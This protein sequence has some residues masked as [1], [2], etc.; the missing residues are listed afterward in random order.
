MGREYK[1]CLS[2]KDHHGFET[3]GRLLLGS[4]EPGNFHQADVVYEELS[5]DGQFSRRDWEAMRVSTEGLYGDP[6][7]RKSV[8]IA[9]LVTIRVDGVV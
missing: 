7:H 3:K 6:L 8:S 5:I 4:V 2:P 1:V 9:M